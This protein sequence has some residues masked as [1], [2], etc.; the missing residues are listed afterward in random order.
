MADILHD[1]SIAAPVERVFE[2]LV[3]PAGLDSWWT[4]ESAG[5]PG[6]G[7]RYRFY[8]GPDHDWS[9]VMRR[10]EPPSAVEWEITDADD[11]WRGTRVGFELIPSPSGSGT[12]V[13]FHHAGWPEGNAHFR[14]SSFCWA[15]YLRLLARNIETGEV[16][17]YARRLEA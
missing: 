13:R 2:H 14:Q 3:S 4:L 11:D 5:R 10:C 8:F 7:E 15:M 1:F 6:V 17:P 9:G 16:V 12:L